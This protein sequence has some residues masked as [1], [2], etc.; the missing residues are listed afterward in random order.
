MIETGK[1]RTSGRICGNIPFAYGSP[2]ILLLYHSNPGKLEEEVSFMEKTSNIYYKFTG[3]H[4]KGFETVAKAE[5]YYL[6]GDIETA[7][8]LCLKAMY[9]AGISS[10]YFWRQ[11]LYLQE[12]RF[13][14]GTSFR[15]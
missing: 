8:I 5:M 10:A 7:E 12:F 14:P 15:L 13:L 1:R 2:S 9:I 4:G 11:I 6:R 3:G